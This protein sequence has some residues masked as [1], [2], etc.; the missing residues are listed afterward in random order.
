M[1]YTTIGG[2]VLPFGC[3][4][5]MGVVDVVVV[6]VEDVA[7]LDGGAVLAFCDVFGLLL[8]LFGFIGVCSTFLNGLRVSCCRA[9]DCREK[10]S[11]SGI[12]S[13]ALGSFGKSANGSL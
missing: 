13:W 11:E 12:E 6:D 1:S 10:L 2:G 4:G 8:E 3:L 5:A 9:G 7:T